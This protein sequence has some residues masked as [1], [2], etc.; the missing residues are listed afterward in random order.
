MHIISHVLS[1]SDV[2][3]L[4]VSLPYPPGDLR[5][6]IATAGASRQNS[7]I[8]PLWRAPF[9]LSGA[10]IGGLTDVQGLK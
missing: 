9:L 6:H 3:F 10:A 1:S 2:A 5:L 8:S 7:W 4:S